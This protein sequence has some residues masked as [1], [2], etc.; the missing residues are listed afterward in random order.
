MLGGYENRM[1]AV[2]SLTVAFVA[3]DRLA[4]GFLAPYLVKAFNLS[5]TQIGALYAAQAGAAA[6]GGYLAGVVS[7][8]T[9]WRKR[10]VVPMLVVMAVFN[11]LSAAASGFMLLLLARTLTGASEGPI[12]TLTQSIVSMQSSSHRRGL[13]MG[14]LTL[15]MFLVS[16]M[17]SPI[18][19]T[20]LADTFGWSAGLLAPAIPALLLAIVGA[21]VLRE[22][23]I[24]LPEQSLAAS[25]QGTEM[26]AGSRNVRLCAVISMVFMSWLVIHGAFLPLY[27]VQVRG[28]SPVHMGVMLSVLGAAGAVGGFL[29]PALSDRIGRRA[30]MLI[31]MLCATITPLGI[32]FIHDSGLLL[33]AALFV[34]WLSVG[35]LP[36]YSVIIPGESVAP[37]KAATAIALVMGCGELV[38]GVFGPL[39][40]GRL[41]DTLGLQTPFYFTVL[42]VLACAVLSLF[43]VERRASDRLSQGFGEL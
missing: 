6:L 42:A 18:V 28:M 7:D 11:L 32:I 43:L 12:A 17:A 33:A 31:A 35:A 16:Q 27:L 21:A 29:Y 40:G 8:R 19:L 25:H 9:G 2:T 20:H 5:N 10:I 24:P 13:N 37:A 4:L 41:A 15:C 36:I 30:T 3:F 22:Q 26:P 1:I 23:P 38:G 39:V 34:G 14:V